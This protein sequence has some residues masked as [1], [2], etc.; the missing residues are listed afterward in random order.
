MRKTVLI[1]GTSSGFGNDIALSLADAG[2][3]VF[4]SMRNLHGR[5]AQAAENLIAK[6]I[7]VLE[8]DVTSDASVAAAFSELEKKVGGRLDVL[9]NNAGLASAGLSETFSAD[10]VQ[11]LFDVN[12]FG[13]QR[14]LRAALPGM[15][16]SGSGLVVN[17]GSIVGRLTI[18]FFG[19]YGASKHAVEALTEGYRYEVSQF[20]VD[21]VLVQ[22]G[23]FPTNLYTSLQ[24]PSDSGRA[25]SYRDVAALPGRI[26]EFLGVYFATPDAPKQHEVAR[27]V[28][29]LV[30]APPGSRPARIVA[31]AAFGADVANAALV[32]LQQ[33]LIAAFGLEQLDKLRVVDSNQ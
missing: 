25:E 26:S 16:K 22:P 11:A 19:I 9:V 18:P 33:Q 15:R 6:G 17:I 10:Q 2:H 3:R 13:L 29:E 12:V 4:A 5:N 14:M 20:G 27:T 30:A 21:V 32:P 1:T 24:Q 23:P 31:G 8:L 7:E 28:V